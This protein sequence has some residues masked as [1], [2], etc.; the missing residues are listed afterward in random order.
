MLLEER[1]INSHQKLR[2]ICACGEESEISLNNFRAR[3]DCYSCRNRKISEAL[4]DSSITREERLK[5]RNVP[6]LR[7]WRKDVYHRDN[8][9]CAKCDERG[10]RLNAHH[11]HNYADYPHERFEINNGITLCEECHII[12]HKKYGY[13]NTN[14]DQLNDFLINYTINRKGDVIDGVS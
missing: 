10:G 5:A 3:K 4:T 12:F 13:R 8:F 11:I 9:T 2:Y 6:E 7:E 14:R 1:F